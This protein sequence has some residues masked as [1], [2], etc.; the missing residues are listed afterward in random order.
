[1]TAIKRCG[2]RSFIRIEHI[3]LFILFTPFSLFNHHFN[4]FIRFSLSA[5]EQR[6]SKREALNE[7]KAIERCVLKIESKLKFFCIDGKCTA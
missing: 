7:T 4:V 5:S 2:P 1:M 3:V 6:A